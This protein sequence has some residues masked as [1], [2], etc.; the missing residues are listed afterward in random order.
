MDS[1]IINLLTAGANLG[2]AG[3]IALI[4]WWTVK[5]EIPR[6]DREAKAERD[7]ALSVYREELKAIRETGDRHIEKLLER[8][9]GIEGKVDGLAR[10]P[11]DGRDHGEDR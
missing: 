5:V 10:R 7:A 3:I 4:H 8:I 9:D 11:F 2:F 1:A 6:R